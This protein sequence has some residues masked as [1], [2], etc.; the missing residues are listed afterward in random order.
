MVGWSSNIYPSGYSG[1]LIGQRTGPLAQGKVWNSATGRY[2]TAKSATTSTRNPAS[3]SISQLINIINQGKKTTIDE[4]NVPWNYAQGLMDQNYDARSEY[5]VPW[6]E[7]QKMLANPG[8]SATEA[9]NMYGQ[10]SDT[11]S[12]YTQQALERM[13]NQL[14]GGMGATV[15]AQRELEDEGQRQRLGAYR[16]IET[17]RLASQRAGRETATAGLAGLAGGKAS[18]GMQAQTQKM[19]LAELLNNMAQGRQGADLTGSL[20]AGALL[21]EVLLG[22]INSDMLSAVTQALRG[23]STSGTQQAS[24][25]S[26]QRSPSGR[27]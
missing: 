4:Y 20:D 9:N 15:E 3:S 1:N 13:G 6:Q 18:A 22:N 27:F 2:E 17:E 21:T 11:I 12:N 19:A 26:L 16:D 24:R 5:D 25:P 14:P 23:S 8:M 7:Y 10:Q